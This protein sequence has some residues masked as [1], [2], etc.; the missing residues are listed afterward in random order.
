M[1]LKIG[2]S[3]ES[4]GILAASDPNQVP[5]DRCLDEIAESG[6]GHIE[7]GPHGYLP[8]DPAVLGAELD[9]RGLTLTAATAIS[10]LEV[11]SAWP[12]LEKTILRNGGLAAELG[13]KF[14]VL[15]DGIYTESD[16]AD[17][18][19]QPRLTEDSWNQL[20]DTTHQAAHL[21]QD[22]LGMELAFH[23]CGDSHVEYEDQIEALLEDTDPDIVSLCLDTGHHAYK[24]GDP[25]AF[26][27]KHHERVSYLH[28]KSVDPGLQKKVSEEKIP[29]EEATKMGVFAEPYLGS[30][31]FKA[32]ANVLDDVGFTGPAMVEQDM[33]RPPLDVPLPI[34]KRARQHFRDT[35]IG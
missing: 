18:E 13:A 14:L 10:S 11:A 32:F 15:I 4:W 28:L 31:D 25:V 5:W 35:G 16:F 17:G 29:I 1:A 30:V 12:E 22:K 24:G 26:M 23:P 2:N 7:L 3:P 9:K 19:T 8:T 20:V 6:F 33:Y 27:S 34:A 21:V